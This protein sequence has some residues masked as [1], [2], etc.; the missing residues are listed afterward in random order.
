[1]MIHRPA[2]CYI[3][4]SERQGWKCPL[5]DGGTVSGNPNRADVE[6][7][8][9][10]VPLPGMSELELLAQVRATSRPILVITAHEDERA[11]G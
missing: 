3:A 10:E 7:L 6:C 5:C 11:R 1:M 9:I 2:G 4:F 8:V